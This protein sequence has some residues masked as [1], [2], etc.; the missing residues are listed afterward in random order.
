MPTPVMILV[1]V[2]CRTDPK[3]GWGYRAECC[4]LELKNNRHS[5][6]MGGHLWVVKDFSDHDDTLVELISETL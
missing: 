3:I 6:R 4:L 5:V 2:G 1:K